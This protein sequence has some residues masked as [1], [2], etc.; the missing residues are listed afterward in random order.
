MSR[1][2][3]TV[4][5][6]PAGCAAP[7]LRRYFTRPVEFVT[8][9][10]F[11]MMATGVPIALNAAI[12]ATHLLEPPLIPKVVLYD[13]ALNT[14]LSSERSPLMNSRFVEPIPADSVFE[15]GYSHTRRLA[16]SGE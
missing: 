5:Y 6:V 9:P 12:N 1:I 15:V 10:V 7:A 2:V 11:D 14:I 16:H 8:V 3:I 13:P 4:V